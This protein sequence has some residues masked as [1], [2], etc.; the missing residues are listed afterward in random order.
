MAK[1]TFDSV[2]NIEFCVRPSPADSRCGF[3]KFEPFKLNEIVAFYNCGC[4]TTCLTSAP[5][6]AH[7]WVADLG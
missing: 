4:K 1:M 2:R 5:S 3:H 7:F 6:D